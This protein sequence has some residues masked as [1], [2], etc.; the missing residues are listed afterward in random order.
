MGQA[1]TFLA[2]TGYV[3]GLLGPAPVLYCSPMGFQLILI[4]FDITLHMKGP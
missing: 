2:G 1:Q 3:P 4:F